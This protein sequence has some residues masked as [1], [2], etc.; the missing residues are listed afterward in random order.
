MTS[1]RTIKG[2]ALTL[3]VVVAFAVYP[4]VAPLG[5]AAGASPLGFV[6]AAMLCSFLGTAMVGAMQRHHLLIKRSEVRGRAILGS[7]F[8][9]EHICL[10]FALHYLAV[11]VAMCLIYTYPFMVGISTA[12]SGRNP[13]A[14]ALLATLLLCLIGIGFVLGFSAD[15]FSFLGISF[16]LA[17]AVLATLRILLTARSV[18]GVPGIVLTT[19]MLT[20]GTIAGMLT[21]PFVGPVFPQTSLGWA[22]VFVAGASGMIGHACLAMALQHI[23]PTPFAVIM[24]LEPVIA[25][26]LAAAIVGQV[27]AP[28]Q[29]LGGVLVVIAV[30]WY[31]YTKRDQAIV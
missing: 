26:V 31:S 6:L 3:V 23:R 8:F 13:G 2:Y 17:Q 15:Q 21:A 5:I 22:A 27:L 1:K 29:Y 11:P 19:Q 18:Q 7:I 25:A 16:A 12:F 9:L 10:L 28:A 30:I 24:N 14:S 20:V 4:S